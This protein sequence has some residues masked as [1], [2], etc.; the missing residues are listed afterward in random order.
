M[1]PS[2]YLYTSS[3]CASSGLH[4]EGI[5]RLSGVKSK[6]HQLRRLYNAGEAVR[7]CDQEP[8]VIASLLKQYLRCVC[9]CVC[10]C[11]HACASLHKIFYSDSFQYFQ[12]SN[13]KVTQ[14]LHS[15]LYSSRV[16]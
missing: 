11:V 12:L 14:F 3:I 16:S 9:V 10:V 1:Y 4:C 15:V 8:H 2:I 7:L 6:V 5:Y 13:A